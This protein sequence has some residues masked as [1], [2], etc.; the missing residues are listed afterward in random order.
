MCGEEECS[1]GSVGW[2]HSDGMTFELPVPLPTL[3]LAVSSGKAHAGSVYGVDSVE[4]Q[5]G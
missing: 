2:R 1:A 3:F 5:P 4:Q